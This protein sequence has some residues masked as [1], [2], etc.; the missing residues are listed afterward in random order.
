MIAEGDNSGWRVSDHSGWRQWVA[1]VM[2]VADS[3][4]WIVADSSVWRVGLE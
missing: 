2:K 3:S 1:S 4:G